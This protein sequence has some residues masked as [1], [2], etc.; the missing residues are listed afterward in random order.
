MNEMFSQGGKGSTGILTNKQAIARKFGVKQNEVVYFAVGVDL[1]GYKV[2]YD[3]TTQRA[4]SLP[5]LPV[6]TTAVSLNEHAILVHSAG[7]VDLGELAATRREFVSLSDTFTTGLV[8]NTRNELLMHNGIGYT[9]LGALPVTISAETNPVGDTNWKPQ[10]DPD[11][12]G[13]LSVTSTISLGDAL[14]GVKQPYSNTTSRTQHDKNYDSVSSADFGAVGDGVTDDTLALQRAFNFSAS[15]GKL[16]V[17]LPGTYLISSTLSVNAGANIRGDSGTLTGSARKTLITTNIALNPMI[18][19]SNGKWATIGGFN[20]DG[21]SVAL[22]GIRGINVFGLKVNS[23]RCN[24]LVVESFVLI[25]DGTGIGCYLNEFNDCHA[26]Q[27]QVGFVL[28]SSGSNINAVTFNRCSV[29]DTTTHGFREFGNNPGRNIAYNDCDAEKTPIGFLLRS[30]GFQVKNAYVEYCT[31]TGISIDGSGL[32][33]PLQSGNI[34]GCTILGSLH[35]GAPTTSSSTGL[36]IKNAI[37]IQVNNM[38]NTWNAVGT[39]VDSTSRW[40]SIN[41]PFNGSNTADWSLNGRNVGIKRGEKSTLTTA[42]LTGAVTGLGPD[43][44]VVLLQP[45]NTVQTVTLAGSSFIIGES[46]ELH[47]QQTTANTGT[48]TLTDS[49]GMVFYGAGL[50]ATTASSSLTLPA[51]SRIKLIKH[52]DTEWW[53]SAYRPTEA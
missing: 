21:N 4:Y 32:T 13:E 40:I 8:V 22:R 42:V 37:N 2:I 1:G 39:Y 25:N 45:G 53:Y 19:V 26:S 36:A 44:D 34:Q 48:V 7:T 27:G 24:N 5:L 18:D 47:L 11:L 50:N 31:T 29:T 6:G 43:Y 28:N 35:S 17:L 33:V 41:E 15:T 52:N 14:I 51:R 16:L 46:I 30:K 23:I 12:R 3:K 10:T 49:G 9:Y 20:I 38:S